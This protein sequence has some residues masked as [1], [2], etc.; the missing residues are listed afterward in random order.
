M[1]TLQSNPDPLLNYIQFKHHYDVEQLQAEL[2]LCLQREWSDHFNQKDYRGSWQS[3]ALRSGS[4][5]EADI[6]A[7]YGVSTYQD[8]ALL[9]RLPY[10][11]EVIDAWACDKE[12]I[13]LLALHPGSE[14]KPHRDLGCNY[15]DGHFRIHIPVQTNANV[16]FKVAEET[17]FLTEGSCW[18]IDFSQTHSIKNDG[19]EVRVHLV[20]DGIRNGWTDQLFTANGYD[21]GLEPPKN[22]Y[23]AG[24]NAQIIAELERM[25]TD[26]ARALI[27]KLKAGT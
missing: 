26:T 23:N 21:P 9:D 3:I 10:F 22:H 15:Q 11:R 27:Q 25:D 1:L 24:T 5:R 12:S 19:N 8:T 14:I 2:S 6:Y 13:R 18:Y 20:L 17:L 4:G 7:N 16:I